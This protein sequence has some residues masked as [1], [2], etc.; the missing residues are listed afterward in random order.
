VQAHRIYLPPAHRTVF[1]HNSGAIRT[2]RVEF[3]TV[4]RN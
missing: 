2:G 3:K 4:F 1:Q